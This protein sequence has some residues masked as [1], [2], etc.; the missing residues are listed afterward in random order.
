LE[1]GIKEIPFSFIKA[2]GEAK[3][4]ELIFRQVEPCISFYL[5]VVTG[6]GS[7]INIF[8]VE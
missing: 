4:K 8:Q 5:R 3:G 2:E 1:H 6:S 7:R